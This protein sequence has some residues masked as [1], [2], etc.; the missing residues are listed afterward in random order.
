MRKR[1]K[2]LEIAEQCLLV[3]PYYVRQLRDVTEETAQK[4]FM[5]TYEGGT[6]KVHY[7]GTSV[8]ERAVLTYIDRPE[9]MKASRVIQA[10]NKLMQRLPD[11]GR[12][13]VIKHFWLNR[14]LENEKDVQRKQVVLRLMANYLGLP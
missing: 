10:T 1:G 13:F 14:A 9:V 8:V 12:L 11:A 5:R 6:S 4:V 3:Y 2:S 7:S